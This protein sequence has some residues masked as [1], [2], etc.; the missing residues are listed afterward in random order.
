MNVTEVFL[1]LCWFKDSDVRT[2]NLWKDEVSPEK[3]EIKF[4][5]SNFDFI[6]DSSHLITITKQYE[7]CIF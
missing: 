1:R 5:L 4:I 6:Q 2:S 3:L 7:M